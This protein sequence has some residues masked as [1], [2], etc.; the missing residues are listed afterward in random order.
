MENLSGSSFKVMLGSFFTLLS[1][2]KNTKNV[3]TIHP[4]FTERTVKKNDCKIMKVIQH[5]FNNE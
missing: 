4:I 5:S 2:N 1:I 3:T